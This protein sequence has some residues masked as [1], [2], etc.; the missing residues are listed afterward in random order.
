MDAVLLAESIPSV[1]RYQM[2]AERLGRGLA[3]LLLQAIKPTGKNHARQCIIMPGFLDG[4]TAGGQA[5]LLMYGC[6]TPPG[7]FGRLA[8]TRFARR[9][10]ETPPATP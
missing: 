8:G 4:E 10:L 7:P 5:A 2:D 9:R 1:A 6:C 3:R